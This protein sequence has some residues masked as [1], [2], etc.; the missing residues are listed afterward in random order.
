MTIT[1]DRDT[2]LANEDMRFISWEHPLVGG[3]ME[4]ILSGEQGNTALTAIKHQALK[5]GI[6][7]LETIYVI[8]SAASDELQSNR[9]LPPTAM[10]FVLDKKG[11]NLSTDLSSAYIDNHSIQ[12]PQETAYQVIRSQGQEIRELVFATD[13]LAQQQAPAIIDQAHK[14]ASSALN[15]EVNRLKALQLVNPNIR[16]EE[17]EFFESQLVALTKILEAATPRLDAV[18]V[19]VTT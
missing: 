13:Q 16:N 17:I 18:R 1:Y 11:K 14:Q 19:I 3:A 7:L 5:P 4:M 6:L 12:I 9:Y 15:K 8:S 10:R 2:A